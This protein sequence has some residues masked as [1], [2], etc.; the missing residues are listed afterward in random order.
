VGVDS[1]IRILI[2]SDIGKNIL[3]GVKIQGPEPRILT[4]SIVAGCAEMM[5][6]RAQR[7]TKVHDVVFEC[8]EIHLRER[9]R[10]SGSVAGD[11]DSTVLA[12]FDGIYLSI[13]VERER[14]QI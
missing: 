8:V 2:S 14:Y 7:D 3:I 11:S 5:H 10:A 13:K 9:E 6:I 12:L 4:G 1:P